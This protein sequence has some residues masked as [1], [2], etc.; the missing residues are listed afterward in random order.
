MPKMTAP[1]LSCIRPATPPTGE[2]VY[3]YC[4]GACDTQAGHGGW[5]TILKYGERELELKGHASETTNNRME[6]TALLEGL[7][8]LKRPCVVLV[9][10]DS[11]Y[12][13]NAFT[14]KWVLNWQK[15]GWKTASK[16]PVKNQDLWEELIA[17]ARVHD[18]KFIWVKG[19]SGHEFNERV[20]KLAV[21]E[22]LKLRRA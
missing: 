21:E 7:K 11:Q 1:I 13:R 5:A 8:I 15:N 12:L 14:Q 10:T 6:L 22:R 4:D 9:V 2:H 20:D 19:H 3:L 16:E 18:L 17:L